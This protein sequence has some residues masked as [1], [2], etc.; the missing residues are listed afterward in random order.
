MKDKFLEY[1]SSDEKIKEMSEYVHLNFRLIMTKMQSEM[2]RK[3]KIEPDL[4]NKDGY[5]SLMCSLQ[6][7][8]FN[9]MV[10]SL[11]GLCQSMNTEFNEIIP[12]ETILI[13]LD[14]MKGDNP[15]NGNPRND[16]PENKEKFNEY[17][18]SQI[19]ALRSEISALPKD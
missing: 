2:R 17:Y 14:L 19:V 1:Y 6:G 15:L 10:Y 4:Q 18:L 7:R 9:E 8:L 16:I 5:V 11:C 13:L 3:L 12:K